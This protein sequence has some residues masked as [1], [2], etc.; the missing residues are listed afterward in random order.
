MM[1]VI[2]IN[3]DSFLMI[4]KIIIIIIFIMKF[5]KFKVEVVCPFPY[6]H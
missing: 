5:L 1:E 3:D 2:L 4:I 6:M